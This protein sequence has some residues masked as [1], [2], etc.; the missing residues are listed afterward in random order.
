M[1]VGGRPHQLADDAER[2]QIQA[3]ARQQAE[4]LASRR[5][6]AGLEEPAHGDEGNLVVGIVQYSRIQ[7]GGPQDL[8]GIGAEYLQHAG[9]LAENPDTLSAFLVGIARATEIERSLRATHRPYSNPARFQAR[10]VPGPIAPKFA[11]VSIASICLPSCPFGL[12]K[13]A[14]PVSVIKY[15][16]E[17]IWEELIGGRAR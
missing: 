15:Q 1:E 13:G 16:A 14:A 3:L 8:R 17:S 12:S 4:M 6:D 7:A 5:L 11:A 9:N 2:L 10:Q